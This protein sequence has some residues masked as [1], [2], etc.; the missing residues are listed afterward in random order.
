[1]GWGRKHAEAIAR[2]CDAQGRTARDPWVD[3]KSRKRRIYLRA[4]IAC[5]HSGEDAGGAKANA[6][7]PGEAGWPG[8]WS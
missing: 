2:E 3:S 5:M 8:D 7:P 4:R 1:L 6:A